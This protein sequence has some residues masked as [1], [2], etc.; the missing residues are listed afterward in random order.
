MIKKFLFLVIVIAILAGGYFY[1]Y[2]QRP[3]SKDYKI[4][5]KVFQEKLTEA[6]IIASVKAALSMH[7]NFTL[8]DIKVRTDNGTVTLSGIL[9]TKEMKQLALSIASN[10]IGVEKVIDDIK[11]DPSAAK[12][13]RADDGRTIGE[14][15]DDAAITAYVKSSFGLNK[16]LRGSNIKVTTFK[17]VVFLEGIV[18]SPEQ[19][20]LAISIALSVNNVRD[21]KDDLIIKQ[22]S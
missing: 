6:K 9:P 11:V 18:G 20:K 12:K 4:A 22:S 10:V 17:R 15:I 1:F 16:K 8:F 13:R 7:R 19:K 21:V 2:K 14:G 3:A 5:R